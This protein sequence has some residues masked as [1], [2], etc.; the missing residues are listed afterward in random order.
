MDSDSKA[1]IEYQEIM[2]EKLLQH[3]VMTTSYYKN[4]KSNTNLS[5]FPVVSKSII[6]ENQ[7]G[8]LSLKYNKNKLIKVSTSGSTGT[9][10]LC[11]QNIEKKRRVNAEII[12]FRGI[13][14]IDIFKVNNE[15][16]ISEVN[17]RFG[18]GY[19]HAYECGVNIPRMII[20]NI[21]GN[22]NVNTIGHYKAGTYM[23]KFNEVK[24]SRIRYK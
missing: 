1:L 16:Y 19:P 9:P 15:Y 18:G 21:Y 10:F 3:A 22:I 8:F 14:D 6:K 24:I 2:L 5:C 17:P 12:F 11:Y 4:Y 20:E 23:M 7:D 13:I